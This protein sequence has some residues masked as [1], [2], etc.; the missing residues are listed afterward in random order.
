M[1]LQLQIERQDVIG[2]RSLTLRRLE[3]EHSDRKLTRCRRQ[4][5]HLEAPVEIGNRSDLIA[6]ALRD[7]RRARNR[8]ATGTHYTV[9]YGST[10]HRGGE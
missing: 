9:L 4:A 8:L 1:G 5:T 2:S 3:S 6:A 10:P 7:H